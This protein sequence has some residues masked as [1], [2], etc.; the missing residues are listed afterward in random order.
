MKRSMIPNPRVLVLLATFLVA[1]SVSAQDK[2]YR[3]I[4]ST[5]TGVETIYGLVSPLDQD[6]KNFYLQNEDG[7]VEVKLTERAEVGLMF[8]ENK[9]LELL[10]DR[11]VVLS[12]VGKREI[13][14]PENLWVKVYF[15]DWKSAQ[16]AVQS[17]KFRDGML[18][19]KPL[20][21]HLPT[22]SALWLS[23]P[24][25]GLEKAHITP[26]KVVTIKGKE[27]RGSTSGHNYAEQVAGLWDASAIQPFINQASAYGKMVNDVFLADYVFLRPIPDQAAQ[28]DPA[29]PRYLFIGDSISG[30]YGAGLHGALD[31]KVNVHHPPTNCGPSGKGRSLA[32]AWLGDYETKGKHWDVISFN[33]GHWDAGNTKDE[34]Q[35]N[36][37]AVIAQLIPTGA[38]LIWVTTCPVPNGYDDA[39]PLEHSG[40]APGRTAGVMEKFLNPWAAEVMARHP[41]IHICDQWKFVKENKGELYTEWWA[42]KNVHFN[43]E[44]ADALGRFLADAVTKVLEGGRPSAAAKS[45]PFRVATPAIPT[46]HGSKRTFTNTSGKQI[47]AD[48]VQLTGDQVVL[49]MN[50]KDYTVSIASLSA[51]DQEYLKQWSKRSATV[52]SSTET[53]NPA[54]EALPN[55]ESPMQLGKKI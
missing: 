30:N 15:K 2:T 43:G 17:G 49:R 25:T 3:S 8:R 14:L 42:G 28:D 1:A 5:R 10:E 41:E 16:N 46:N 6:G 40:K 38:K 21:D 37:E 50:E 18:S 27:Y 11:K 55:T 19:V 23:G 12:K 32:G 47:E 48:L 9:N 22:E 35:D 13:P 36:L 24:L 44:P 26:T 29:L 4:K 31:S 20:P 52:R 53:S 34:Y 51:A 39:G 45:P 54:K 7:L 33:F